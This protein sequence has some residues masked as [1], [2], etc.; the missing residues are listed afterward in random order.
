MEFSFFSELQQKDSI[1]KKMFKISPTIFSARLDMSHRELPHAFR[2]VGVLVD[3]TDSGEV[4]LC[5]QQELHAQ[6]V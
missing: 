4:P 3:K 1:Y 6:G 5:C 2:N